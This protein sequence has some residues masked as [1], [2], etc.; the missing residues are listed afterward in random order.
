MAGETDLNWERAQGDFQGDK[1][2]IHLYC[3]DGHTGVSI[4]KTQHS[5]FAMCEFYHVHF[6][7]KNKGGEGTK[8]LKI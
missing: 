2:V 8:C 5:T 6:N 3:D 4:V 1:N 7:V